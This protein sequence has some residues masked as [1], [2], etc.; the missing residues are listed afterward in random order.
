MTLDEL[1]RLKARLDALRPLPE[2]TLRS[3]H[4]DLVLRWTYHSNAI[5]GN[6]LTLMETR[7]VLQD[8][9]TIGGKRLREHFEAINH[10]DAIE[11][12]ME[13]VK[14]G[15]PFCEWQ[16]RNIHR[17]VLK[18]IDDEGAG[19]YRTSNVLIAGARHTPPDALL[20]AE[21]MP[22]FIRWYEG[23][24]MGMHP[25]KRAAL[26][27]ARF[28]GIHPFIDRNGRTARL[29]MNLELLKS[30]FPPAVLPVERRL[31][32]YEALDKAHVD[33]DFTDF[34]QLIAECCAEGFDP[35]WR[36]LGMTR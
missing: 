15:E 19:R 16:I 29:L 24:G 22:A 17:L 35:Y 12:V 26:V 20:L 13:I 10:R 36:V 7:L 1:D 4:D 18:N 11:Y 14:G 21:L 3:L 23:E 5:E 34:I 30:G 8:G 9:L 33:D 32:Y 27:H 2:A 25:V 31:A 28:V 6:T